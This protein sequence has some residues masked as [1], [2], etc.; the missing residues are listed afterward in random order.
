[1]FDYSKQADAFWKYVA[2]TGGITTATSVTLKTSTT[3]RANIL[4]QIEMINTG[5]TATEVAILR[6]A[7]ELFRTKL[8]ASM[9][10]QQ[11]INFD[12]PLST[13]YAEALNFTVATAGAEVFVNAQGMTGTALI[14]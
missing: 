1:M 6:G 10:A 12:P 14:T 7:V 9:T 3:A 4:V 8:P 2:A 5:G 13:S 11:V